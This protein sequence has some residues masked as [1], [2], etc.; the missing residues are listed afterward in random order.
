MISSFSGGS[1]FSILDI[2]NLGVS[3][4]NSAAYP[5][6]DNTRFYSRFP[7]VSTIS[8]SGF[9]LL[10]LNNVS[11][12]TVNSAPYLPLSQWATQQATTTLDMSQR[13]IINCSTLNGSVFPQIIP[14]V[15]D[16]TSNWALFFSRA[17]V[18]MSNRSII[19][20]SQINNAPYPPPIPVQNP[21][22][23]SR[24]PALQDTAYQNHSI[25]GAFNG[26]FSNQIQVGGLF[27]TLI[28]GGD[29]SCDNIDVGNL[30]TGQADVNIYGVNLAPLDSA[31]Y[32]QGGT[33]LDGG[34]SIHGITIGTLPVSGVN[35]QRIDVLPTGIT[36]TTPS[37]FTVLG[38]G[39][40]T[41][42]VGGAISLAAGGVVSLAAGSYVEVNSSNLHL[43]N[44][45]SG[46]E[47]TVI[48]VG[49]VDGPYNVSN[50]YPL[51][52]GNSGSA[53]TEIVNLISINGQPYPGTP[54]PSPTPA[55]LP[56]QT[57]MD[58]KPNGTNGG[59][60]SAH[61]GTYSMR[62]LNTGN[63]A[64]LPLSAPIFVSSTIPELRL[65]TSSGLISIP[66][67]TYLVDVFC[68]ITS[69][70]RSRCRI[71]DVSNG[72]ELAKGNNTFTST[73][74]FDGGAST[75]SCV[76]S[77]FTQIS[78]EIQQQIEFNNGFNPITSLGIADVFGDNEG[79]TSVR[80]VRM[81][82]ASGT[83][84]TPPE[85]SNERTWTGYMSMFYDLL[86]DT[87]N[88]VLENVSIF[89]VFMGP[90]P[91]ISGRQSAIAYP[92][93]NLG[94]WICIVIDGGWEKTVIMQ[95]EKAE[96]V[97]LI[98][99]ALTGQFRQQNSF[100]QWSPTDRDLNQSIVPT[101]FFGGDPSG[102]AQQ[103]GYAITGFTIDF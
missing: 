14:P 103:T 63:P 18:N 46:N 34:G 15:V 42:T 30:A 43:I 56:T 57:F 52:L 80:F 60:G 20:L 41:M 9:S 77:V 84:P 50:Q 44:T 79:Y 31:L 64:L 66:P 55:M 98:F 2:A 73:N 28:S 100:P 95:I 62:M 86:P 19:N 54:G 26:F 87:E 94:E 3:S 11:L 7:F 36:L 61:I 51:I 16:N 6:P 85:P 88:A 69:V 45:T 48:N 76:I 5:P 68:P 72:I 33:T 39:A 81:G 53:G 75:L 37:F 82:N 89:N 21:D 101:M 102:S 91:Q 90:T 97:G 12:S 35:T 47:N 93:L 24:F 32:V 49:R 92:L 59:D 70:G 10:N 74:S 40:I 65:D 58:I 13:G 29:I 71:F 27:Q 4:I 78:I 1:Q 99:R 17:D 67:G 38:A 83:P 22:Q 25:T 96:G 23:W 8:A